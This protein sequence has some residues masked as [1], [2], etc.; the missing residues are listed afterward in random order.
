MRID[1]DLL[2]QTLLAEGEKS[3]WLQTDAIP[4]MQQMLMAERKSVRLLLVEFLSHIDRKEATV[5]LAQRAIF[6]L[7]TEVREAAI[8]ALKDRPAEDYQKILVDGLS[9]PW[10][11]VADHASEALIALDMKAAVPQLIAQLDMGD[12]RLITTINEQGKPLVMVRELVRVNHFKNC[13]LCHA[14]SFQTADLVRGAIPDP[15]QPLPAASTPEYYSNNT[16]PAVRADIT[17]LRQDFSVFQPVEK[18]GVWPTYQRFDYLVRLR[19]MNPAD[20]A[21][22]PG[23]SEQYQAT[24]YTLQK[25]TG[26]NPGPAPEDWKRLLIQMQTPP[27]KSQVHL[28]PRNHR[29]GDPLNIS[30][31]PGRPLRVPA[32]FTTLLALAACNQTEQ[33]IWRRSYLGF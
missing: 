2:R 20:L 22:K 12:P 3:H 24:L 9:Y 13:L 7:N 14:P 8:K 25:L 27:N 1:P 23:P 19:P 28:L 5:A 6:D 33:G 32:R 15:T 17:Y 16:R 11:P 31:V 26:K 29:A 10:A 30:A 18:P 21:A 4:T